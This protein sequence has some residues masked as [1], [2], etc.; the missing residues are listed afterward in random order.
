[1]I[2]LNLFADLVT[3][4]L[5]SRDGG[6]VTLP[7]LVLGD[8]LRC[9]LR[10]YERS[11]S[12]DLRER[13]LRTRTLRASIGK[14]LAAPMSGWFKLWIGDTDTP[15]INFDASADAFATA[16]QGSGII[17]SVE[18]PVPGTWVIKTTRPD[19]EDEWPITVRF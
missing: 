12:G 14:V 6:A 19:T 16:G 10:T 9:T 13:D 4:K 7:I 15:Q 17:D 11:E 3:R 2:D 5:I 8:T 18:S 1:M